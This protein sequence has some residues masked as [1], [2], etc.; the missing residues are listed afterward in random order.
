MASKR[1]FQVNVTSDDEE[2]PRDIGGVSL[3]KKI[4]EEEK[5]SGDISNNRENE[6]Q[7]SNKEKVTD[8]TNVAAST[9]EKPETEQK[10]ATAATNPVGNNFRETF[11]YLKKT[12]LFVLPPM[13]QPKE[14]VQ[15][16]FLFFSFFLV[17]PNILVC[18]LGC[19]ISLE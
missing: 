4:R 9:S 8:P 10:S 18:T 5:N 7:K 11:S 1:K 14:Y 17:T 16:I 15:M 12:N 2:E 6:V 19:Q 3:F 13:P